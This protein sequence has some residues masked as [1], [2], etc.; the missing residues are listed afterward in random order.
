MLITGIDNKEVL[1][2]AFT[3]AKSFRPMNATEVAN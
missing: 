1:T 2:Q 3:A